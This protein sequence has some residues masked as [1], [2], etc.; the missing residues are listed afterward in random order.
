MARRETGIMVRLWER[1]SD[2]RPLPY[3]ESLGISSLSSRMDSRFL[4]NDEKRGEGDR[5][6]AQV[7]RRGSE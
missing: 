6:P 2:V 5:T 1:R 4:G 7:S 3:I